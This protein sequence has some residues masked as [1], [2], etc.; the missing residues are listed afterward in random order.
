MADEQA[1]F[2]QGDTPGGPDGETRVGGTRVDPAFFDAVNEYLA[3][4]ESQAGKF[5]LKGS[6]LASMFA[7]ARLNAH[8][9]LVNVKPINAANERTAFLDYIST[10]YRRMLNEHLDGMGEER[11]I[12]VGDSE[13]SDEYRAAGVKIGRLKGQ[14]PASDYVAAAGAVPPAEPAKE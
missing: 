7:S 9:F 11:G 12:D 14:T 4:G 6:T 10:M 8:M 2:P 3:V 13:L 5:D 1:Q